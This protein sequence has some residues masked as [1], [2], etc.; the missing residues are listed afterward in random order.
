MQWNPVYG[1]EDLAENDVEKDVKS[2]VIHHPSIRFR[3]VNLT[4]SP[5]TYD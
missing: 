2:Q 5:K 1:L 3:S 4:E